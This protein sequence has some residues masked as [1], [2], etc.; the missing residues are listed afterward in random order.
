MV[1]GWKWYRKTQVP[2][3][4]NLKKRQSVLTGGYAYEVWL[5]EDRKNYR[6]LKDDRDF[7]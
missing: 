1:V 5:F 6:I 2:L 7:D 4:K 3:D